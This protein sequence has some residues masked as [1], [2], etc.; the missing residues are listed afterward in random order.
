MIESSVSYRYYICDMK[1]YPALLSLLLISLISCNDKAVKEESKPLSMK[2]YVSDSLHVSFS[3]PENWDVRIN[4]SHLGIFEALKDSTDKFEENIV[5]WTEDMPLGISDSLY[6]KAA[7]T[8]LKIKN[9]GLDVHVLPVKKLGENTFYPFEFNFANADS[10]RFF[11]K[12]Y[13]LVKD[14]RGYNFSCTSASSQAEVHS[15]LFETI[16]SSVKPL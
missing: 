12:G 7:V 3:Y 13:T 11:I 15:S 5:M 9:P 16:L 8:E 6:S 10:T 2:T 14:K 4:G 1:Y